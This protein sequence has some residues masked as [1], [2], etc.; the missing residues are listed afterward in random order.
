M[1]RIS[2][3]HLHGGP[4]TGTLYLS[5][6]ILPVAGFQA[7]LLISLSQ[8]FLFTLFSSTFFT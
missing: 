8:T 7:H 6:S 4:K 5:V 2:I 3:N 1:T